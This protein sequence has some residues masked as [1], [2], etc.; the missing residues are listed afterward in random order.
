MGIVALHINFIN[1][2][3]VFASVFASADNL[4]KQ[5]VSKLF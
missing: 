3:S 1:C 2:L 4:C 5:F